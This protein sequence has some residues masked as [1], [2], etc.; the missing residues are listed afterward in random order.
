M[1]DDWCEGDVKGGVVVIT[2][3]YRIVRGLKKEVQT[4]LNQWNT[5]Y[6]T[7]E[8][9]SFVVETTGEVHRET[10]YTALVLRGR[11]EV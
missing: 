3:E 5:V 1:S 10:I 8:V 6:D 4:K 7:F 2:T 9:C 11:D